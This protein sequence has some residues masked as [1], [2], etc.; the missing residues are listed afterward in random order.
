MFKVIKPQR[1][2]TDKS[3]TSTQSDKTM[4]RT[5]TVVFHHL[6]IVKFYI[7]FWIVPSI[8]CWN[9]CQW[10]LSPIC[11]R[12][13]SNLSQVKLISV[14]KRSHPIYL[15]KSTPDPDPLLSGSHTFDVYKLNWDEKPIYTALC[16]DKWA[17][18]LLVWKWITSTYNKSAN[19]P[20]STHTLCLTLVHFDICN[21]VHN[22]PSPLPACHTPSPPPPLPYSISYRY[23]II[24]QF[25]TVSTKYNP[26][27]HPLP[28]PA[29]PLVLIDKLPLFTI[30]TPSPC[31]PH[32]P[33][34]TS[35]L[36]LVLIDK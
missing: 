1:V 14:K 35:T 21:F 27:L 13:Q 16:V 25:P 22:Y 28:L 2:L 32:P 36:Q 10:D 18:W 11:E 31:L 20:C 5:Q 34:P 33:P 19:Q 7:A 17:M 15:A 8:L 29:L 3:M 4:T 24:V 23:V 30:S 6:A 26:L 9:L 12:F